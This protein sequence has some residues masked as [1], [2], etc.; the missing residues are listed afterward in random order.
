MSIAAVILAAGLG[1]RFKSKTAKV[2]HP[3]LGLPMVCYPLRLAKELGLEPRLVVVGHQA[4]AVKAV[5]QGEGVEFVHQAEQ[6]GTGH[7]VSCTAQDLQ[8]F[9]GDVLILSG[10]VPLLRPRTVQALIERHLSGQATLSFMTVRL[11]DPSGY[12]RVLRQGW[13]FVIV[14]DKDAGP[15]EKLI[16]EVNVGIYL[17]RAAFLFEVL[18]ELN[19]DN[20]QQEYYLPEIVRLAG[21]EGFKCLSLEVADA[22]EVIGINTRWDLAQAERRLRREMI[23]Q[24]ALDGVTC[25]DPE[26]LYLDRDVTVG[27][28][29]WLGAGVHLLAGTR[30]GSG[31]TVEPNCYLKATQVGDGA[32]IRSGARLEN[33]VVSP[34]QII[35]G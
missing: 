33:A 26:A 29:T 35:G 8:D 7:A 9:K 25:Q 19:P 34:G 10:D 17:V 1:T 13:R 16:Q 28:D 6:L 14:E 23:R 32:V 27:P 11:A 21:E 24:L 22:E 5:C 31:V 18:R 3:L 4:E 12:G 30:L 2:L 20:A 15:A